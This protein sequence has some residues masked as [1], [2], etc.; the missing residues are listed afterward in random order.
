MGWL[1]AIRFATKDTLSGNKGQTTSYLL[2]LIKKKKKGEVAGEE[3]E[4][5]RNDFF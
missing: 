1:A 3:E 5:R 2:P 4:T